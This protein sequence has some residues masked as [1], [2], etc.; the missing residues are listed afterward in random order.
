MTDL[1]LVELQERQTMA[2]GVRE[3]VGT[4][5]AGGVLF[6]VGFYAYTKVK[7]SIDTGNFTAAEN[8]TYDNITGNVTS[9]FDLGSVVFIVLAAASIIGVIWLAF[10]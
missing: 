7:G 9:G 6:M 4:L 10:R 2:F 8:T 3:T 5:V 1:R